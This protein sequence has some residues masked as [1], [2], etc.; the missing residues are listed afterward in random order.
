M[1]DIRK[2]KSLTLVIW[3]TGVVLFALGFYWR[4]WAVR[5]LAIPTLIGG[6][7][8][9]GLGLFSYYWG[10]QKGH[11]V[12]FY[13]IVLFCLFSLQFFLNSISVLNGLWYAFIPLLI[14][15][16]TI[17]IVSKY[18]KQFWDDFHAGIKRDHFNE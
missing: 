1:S 15:G 16:V 17:S 14:A 18:K 10:H 6:S 8:W 5:Q 13:A 9:A 3:L 12:R 11:P 2:S 7:A 4:H